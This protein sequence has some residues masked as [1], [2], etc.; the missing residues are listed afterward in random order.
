MSD[1]ANFNEIRL[2][3]QGATMHLVLSRPEARN[4][5]SVHMGEEIAAAVAQINADRDVRVVLVRGEGQAFAA[6]G[7]F[8]F[9]ADRVVDESENN[10]R[11][12]LDY[13]RRFLTIRALHVPSIAVIH[14]AAIGAGL[15]FALACDIRY[16]A[17]E[18]QL[19]VNFVRLGLHPGMG[20]TYFLPRLVG[21]ARAAE[22][23]LSGR[24]IR[25]EEASRM[26]LVNAV[27]P[28]EE[29]LAASEALAAEI[30]SCAPL[31]VTRTKASLAGALGRDLDEALLA[32]ASAQALD[33]ATEDMKEGIAAA[34]ERRN[35]RFSGR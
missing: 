14:G 21:P 15:C 28:V 13:Y 35:P 23:L 30:A 6:G 18:A 24:R 34:R 25:A 10:R 31:A 19:G 1:V 7:D 29:L 27:Y 5:M 4:A 2:Q 16:A 11:V 20:A 8:G 9:I 17:P 32:E 3:K 26:G 12:M 22:L 33:Y